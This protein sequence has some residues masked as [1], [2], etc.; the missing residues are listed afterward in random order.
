LRDFAAVAPVAI[1]PLV[2]VVRP[3]APITS[4][5][6]LIKTAKAQPGKIDYGTTGVGSSLHLAMEMLQSD[7]GTQMVHVPYKGSGPSLTG[8]LGGEIQVLIDGIGS[9]MPLVK[10]GK[11]RALAVTSA[12]RVSALPDVPTVAE[13]GYPKFEVTTWYG[14]MA[15]AKT[16]EV[17]LN[18]LNAAIARATADKGF[19]DQFEALGLIMPAPSKPREFAAYIR[20]ESARWAPL[21]KAKNIT[22]D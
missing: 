11:L 21:I 15:P 5:A 9:S 3:D 6:E 16:P 17:V 4:L 14:V 8:V 12:Q 1:T 13:S 2:I 7:T 22:L 10:G 19:R 18:R 20:S